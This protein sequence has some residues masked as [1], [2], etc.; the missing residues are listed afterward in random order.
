MLKD[1]YIVSFGEDWKRHPTCSQH[2]IRGLLNNNKVIWIN[3]ISFRSPKLNKSD[4]GRLLSKFQNWMK[5]PED[6]KHPSLSLYSPLVFP[7]YQ[8]GICRYING[9]ILK[10]AVSSRIKNL[11]FKNHILWISVPTASDMV[12]RLGEKLSVYYCQDEFASFPG[13]PSRTIRKMEDKLLTESDIVI[14]ISEKLYNEKKKYNKSTYLVTHGVEFEHFY[15][16]IGNSQDVPSELSKIKRPIIGYYGL[17][18]A[19][20][21][22]E[23]LRY[24]AEKNPSWSLVLIGEVRCDVEK[25]KNLPNIYFL[26]P[27]KYSDLPKYSVLFDVAIIPHKVNELTNSMTPTKLMEYLAAGRHVVSA[28][29]DGVKRF[30]DTIDI[31]ETYDEFISMIKNNL[32][33]K[34]INIKGIEIAKHSRWEAK[35]EEIS[36]IIEK[37]YLN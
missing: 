21:D 9:K 4:F 7:Y 5:Q 17:I 2:I 1:K 34:D 13:V 33:K 36:Q 27:K 28:A 32:E 24:I 8:M 20:T 23:L 12:G 30:R 18:E 35:I 16:F 15:N 11:G 26:G 6:K 14:A 29:I 25:L 19:W 31:A 37:H 10:K 22:Q 3:S